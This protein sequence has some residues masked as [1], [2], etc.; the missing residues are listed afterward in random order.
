MTCNLTDKS[1]IEWAA[2]WVPDEPPGQRERF[3][4]A[5]REELTRRWP[6]FD[7]VAPSEGKEEKP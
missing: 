4:T 5:L 7:T 6:D 3:A 2:A 1:I